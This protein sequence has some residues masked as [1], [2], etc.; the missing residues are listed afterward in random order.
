MS[1]REEIYFLDVRPCI[2]ETHS[3]KKRIFHLEHGWVPSGSDDET[4]V[5]YVATSKYQGLSAF[6]G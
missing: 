5:Q 6:T 3:M 2:L 4:F 1:T